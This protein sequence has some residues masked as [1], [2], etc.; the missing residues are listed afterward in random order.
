MMR[1]MS[2]KHNV[3]IVSIIVAIIFV[4][5]IG[6]LAYTQMATPG[7]S[8]SG[9][10]SVGIVDPSKIQSA[11]NPLYV[12]AGKEYQEYSQ[13]LIQEA[14]AKM[15]AAADDQAKA[16]IKQ[17]TDAALEAKEAELM[18]NLT[19]KTDEAAKAVGEA[20]GLSVVMSKGA[21]VYGGVD[22][23]DQVLHKLTSEASVNK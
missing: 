6:A 20:K 14:Q 17:E 23:T 10:S 11:E 5:G 18:K 7:V 9:N 16:Q 15:A 3:R 8:D 1:M 22:I 13:K 21:V 19:D 12:A 4:V 2:N